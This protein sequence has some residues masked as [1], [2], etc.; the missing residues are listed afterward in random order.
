MSKKPI[1]TDSRRMS[2]RE[3]L[4]AVGAGAA[5][6]AIGGGLSSC[7]AKGGADSAASEALD[8]GYQKVINEEY[9]KLYD[10]IAEQK[11]VA[12]RAGKKLSVIVAED[13]ISR[14][15]LIHEFMIVD[16]ATRLGINDLVVEQGPELL[17][18]V[19]QRVDHVLSQRDQG[20][21]KF[22]RKHDAAE[23][24]REALRP[25][26]LPSRVSVYERYNPSRHKS[27]LDLN[28]NGFITMLRAKDLGMHFHAGDPLMAERKA[29]I[30]K[31]GGVADDE[32]LTPRFEVPMA[33]AVVGSSSGHTIAI[34]GA[35]HAR[36]IEKILQNSGDVHPVVINLLEKIDGPPRNDS[37]Q[38]QRINQLKG[39]YIPKMVA[40]GLE[41]EP[42]NALAGAMWAG[43]EH[44][45]QLGEIDK[46]TYNMR[47]GVI[48]AVRQDVEAQHRASGR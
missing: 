23:E 45:F 13:H 17:T 21:A 22:M 34:F 40:E 33:D 24:E 41:Y 14:S 11:A 46:E 37:M 25:L 42:G 4:G 6:T 5:A 31:T 30:E 15:S 3:F 27:P 19:L 10:H 29:M 47:L 2:R 12:E 48:S 44:A 1:G 39:A 43:A 28:S 38:E 26:Y 9:A 16:I 36:G 7:N 8:L 18:K 35:A 20:L 32:H